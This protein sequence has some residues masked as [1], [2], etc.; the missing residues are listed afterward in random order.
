[1]ADDWTTVVSKTKSSTKRKNDDTAPI[2]ASQKKG[3][4]VNWIILCLNCLILC[5]FVRIK[6]YLI[7]Y[8]FISY[9][10]YFQ[11]KL[12][13][14]YVVAYN[15]FSTFP[16]KKKHSHTNTPDK[17][18]IHIFQSILNFRKYTTPTLLLLYTTPIPRKNII[19]SF[20]N[21]FTILWTYFL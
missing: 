18:T 11:I 3:K 9:L 1:M 4:A 17:T 8:V 15:Y 20:N 10:F 16:F 6:L 2:K 13:F 5:N 21:I 12:H 19:P 14:L 7:D